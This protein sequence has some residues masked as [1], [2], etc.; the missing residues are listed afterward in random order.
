MIITEDVNKLQGSTQ[1]DETFNNEENLDS[2]GEYSIEEDKT[3]LH[4]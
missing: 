3:G 1:V 4:G 2:V